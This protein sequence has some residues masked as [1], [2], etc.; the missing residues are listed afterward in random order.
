MTPNKAVG[1]LE[2]KRGEPEKKKSSK[3]KREGCG[4]RSSPGLVLTTLNEEC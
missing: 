3:S 2:S 4:G 1:E